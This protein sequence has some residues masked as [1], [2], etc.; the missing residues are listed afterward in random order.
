MANFVKPT[1]QAQTRS[2]PTLPW[3]APRRQNH[4]GGPCL[5]HPV[6]FSVDPNDH[7][8]PVGSRWRSLEDVRLSSLGRRCIRK[9]RTAII[10][11][12]FQIGDPD[13]F[14]RRFIAVG[15]SEAHMFTHLPL[16]ACRSLRGLA[17][18]LAPPPRFQSC[19]DAQVIAAPAPYGTS[20]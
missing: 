12:R 6:Q 20:V 17:R 19:M 16:L 14:S 9:V 13:S 11:R 5:F 15:V 10:Y 8:Y 2:L 3:D 4:P 1:A 18:A 7:Q